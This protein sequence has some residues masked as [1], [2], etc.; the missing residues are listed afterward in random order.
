[1]RPLRDYVSEMLRQRRELD[2]PFEAALRGTPRQGQP[3]VFA[4]W[5]VSSVRRQLPDSAPT[6]DRE[7]DAILQHGT[8]RSAEM[9]GRA[10]SEPQVRQDQ[11][12]HRAR[13][14]ARLAGMTVAA[15][16]ALATAALAAAA[17]GAGAADALPPPAQDVYDRAA[18]VVREVWPLRQGGVRPE[19]FRPGGETEHPDPSTNERTSDRAVMPDSDTGDPTVRRDGSSSRPQT[20]GREQNDRAP[21]AEQSPPSRRDSD[22]VTRNDA[23]EPGASPAGDGTSEDGDTPDDRESA[24][25]PDSPAPSGD[26]TGESDSSTGRPR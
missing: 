26:G 15:K 24:V 5:F 10:A 22:A 4:G 13:F 20:D 23:T 18:A 12:R 14:A 2:E 17:A 3:D 11:R 19:D 8:G 16:L 6:P 21:E 1:M 25:T 7:L 9:P